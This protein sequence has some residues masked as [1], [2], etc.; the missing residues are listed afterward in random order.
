M[1]IF[2]LSF[3]V[4]GKGLFFAFPFKS[5]ESHYVRRAGSGS[6]ALDQSPKNCKGRQ[7]PW[8][9]LDRNSLS[10]PLSGLPVPSSVCEHHEWKS[11]GWEESPPGSAEEQGGS[12]AV[13]VPGRHKMLHL[14]DGFPAVGGDDTGVPGGPRGVGVPWHAA[15]FLM[16][17]AG[18]AWLFVA[19]SR[20]ARSAVIHLPPSTYTLLTMLR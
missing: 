20:A 7:S 18:T 15:Q 11:L 19:V 1:L 2:T 12:Q 3:M 13:T 14:Q 4:F 9:E 5:C 10:D 8:L 17:S 6:G 16:K